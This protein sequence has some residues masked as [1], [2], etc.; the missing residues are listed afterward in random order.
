[1]GSA[2][3]TIGQQDKSAI[4]PVMSG[5]N[6]ATVIN[7]D[8]GPII[9]FLATSPTSL[10]DTYYKPNNKKGSSWNGAELL[11]ANSNSVW[12]TRAIHQDAKYSASLV[13]F[14]TDATNLNGFPNPLQLPDPVVFPLLGGI[15]LT[16]L[17]SYQFPSYTTNRLYEDTSAITINSN[18]GPV[19]LLNT[20]ELSTLASTSGHNLA[21]GD[22]LSFGNLVND[23]VATYV[24]RSAS[25][26]VINENTITLG[27]VLPV[28][29]VAG[30][31]LRLNSTTSFTP[32]IFVQKDAAAGTNTLVVN[33]S[34]VLIN[35]TT[36]V[37]ITAL[38]SP[39]ITNKVI[40]TRNANIVTFV[41]TLP[42]IAKTT[43]VWWMVHGKTEF[44]DAFLVT[45][46]CPGKL[47]D[48]IKV[49]IRNSTNYPGIAFIIDEYFDG[50]LNA[51]YEVTRDPFIDGFG[52]QLQMEKV[53][54]GISKY[55]VVTD[56]T[57]DSTRSLPL[58]S[59]RGLWRQNSYPLYTLST[60]SII[61]NL[62]VGDN[63]ITL[64]SSLGLEVGTSFTVGTSNNQYKILANYLVAS[65]STPANTIQL[66]RPLLESHSLTDNNLNL[67]I[68]NPLLDGSEVTA[69]LGT[70]SLVSGGQ[71]S[72]P[73]GT[74][75]SF[76]SVNGEL[77]ASGILPFTQ[78][79]VISSNTTSFQLS[80]TLNGSPILT[81]SG[82]G[83]LSINLNGVYSGVQYYKYTP[84]PYSTNLRIGD[85]LSISGNSGLIVDAGF[86]NLSSGFDGSTISITDV[87][88][89]FNL[90]GN[91]EKYKISAFC[92]NGFTY[93][94][95]ALAIDTICSHN[96]LAHGCLSTPY[97]A[98]IS[99][100]PVT[101]CINYRNTNTGLNSLNSAYSSLYTG[102]IKVNDTYNQ[103]K[104]MIAPS[105]FG[106]NVLSFVTRNYFVFTPAAGWV[107]GIISGLDIAVKY[108]EGQRDALV[109]ANINPIRFREGFGLAIWGN[110]TLYVK[111]SPL[112]LR[113]VAMLLIVLK[114]GLE[115]YL[116][117]KLFAQNNKPTWTEV[118]TTLNIFIRDTLF[119]PGGLYAWQVAVSQIITDT[120]INNR[121]M[122]VHIGI[123]PTSDIKTIPVTLGIFNKS[124]TITV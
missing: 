36:T 9:P 63:F 45:A 124:V 100:D 30:T 6:I 118:E 103:T 120:D 33:N 66:D 17:A 113:S 112:Q 25:N 39:L 101:A 110:E 37:Y 50:L 44:R 92:D 85:Q 35:N 10:L 29:I 57:Q 119:I 48:R 11:L 79:Y 107:T 75:V 5:I 78:Y 52:N 13:R 62:L 115:N 4:V 58:V 12:I 82:L 60:K 68:F 71:F 3:V 19:G 67:N 84:I 7:S 87:A 41:D 114:Y 61:E 40:N 34:D 77:L 104:V 55:I 26:Q 86:N 95:V 93:P 2:K 102:W 70:F 98:D 89:A 65:G 74:L 42:S 111:P 31:E 51:S 53:I 20:L 43:K 18:N 121:S 15:S 32:A 22:T 97:T 69:N 23:S 94:E 72:L 108:D 99:A 109:N 122:P 90:M 117:F 116:E 54:N 76:D 106:I 91:K 81:A 1:M 105:V 47:G 21:S 123:Q 28:D 56:N 38:Y 83:K 80:S 49:G 16:G 96:Q 88:N 73:N 14:K 8:W 64:N 46:T 27:T 24:I 59:T